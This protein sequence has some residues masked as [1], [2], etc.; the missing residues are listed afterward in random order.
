MLTFV[1]GNDQLIFPCGVINYYR[2]MAA[3]YGKNPN[4]PDFTALYDF[5]RLF[6]APGVGHCGGGTTHEGSLA[7]QPQNLFGALVN[8][9]ENDVPPDQIAT[10]GES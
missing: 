9:V 3:L 10:A 8:W 4:R 1:G 5:Y 6:R 7:R 2:Q